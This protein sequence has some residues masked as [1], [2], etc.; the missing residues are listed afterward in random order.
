M[1]GSMSG[2]ALQ[3]LPVLVALG[4][5]PV[6]AAGCAGGA[7]PYDWR[8]L[9]P[10]ED[11]R[12]PELDL[13]RVV[14]PATADPLP[15]N[16]P[17]WANGFASSRGGTT[18]HHLRLHDAHERYSQASLSVAGDLQPAL[19]LCV[20]G[21]GGG[22]QDPQRVF[23]HQEGARADLTVWGRIGSGHE[24]SASGPD[25][26]RSF[27]FAAPAT[28]LRVGE[29]IELRVLDRDL[30]RHDGLGSL[31]MTYEGTLPLTAGDE[32]LSARCVA[33]SPEVV[34]SRGPFV[35]E[36]ADRAIAAAMAADASQSAQENALS[37]SLAPF[38]QART[39]VSQA[40][41][42]L[43]WSDERVQLRRAR[44][45]TLV[46]A[47]EQAQREA[48]EAL[49]DMLATQ[50]PPSLPSGARV[51][52]VGIVC[53]RPAT[54]LPRCVARFRMDGPSTYVTRYAQ[55]YTLTRAGRQALASFVRDDGAA[56]IYEIE[57]RE[58][59]P[60]GRPTAGP[61]SVILRLA[62]SNRG[63]WVRLLMR[64]VEE[65]QPP[66]PAAAPAAAPTSP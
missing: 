7:Q 48:Y 21:Y 57:L 34:R 51:Q 33:E 56:R 61:S 62:E 25:N 52:A 60:G 41:E 18:R 53:E 36:Q 38:E 14:W 16:V 45:D 63:P 46:E 42:W 28:A 29:R 44:L 3:L 6:A 65:E 4:A 54:G 47:S 5:T 23:R 26:A 24:W 8:E 2:R 58:F 55:A 13:T 39:A 1:L 37:I 22:A 15:T 35:L 59:F 9:P 64:H 66:A 10:E 40:A 50:A 17:W 19:L 11:G 49:E 20:I 30:V 31:S 32:L 12:A 27:A 43:S